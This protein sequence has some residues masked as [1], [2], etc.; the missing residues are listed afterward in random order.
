[1]SRP[2]FPIHPGPCAWSFPDATEADESGIVCAGADLEPATLLAAY[3]K[4]LVPMRLSGRG[5][6]LAWWAPD[7]RGVLPLDGFHVSRSLHKSR[8]K[9]TVTVDMEFEAV[10]GL[11]GDPRRPHGWITQD[12]VTAYVRMHELGW[13]HSFEVWQDDDLVGGMYGLRIK[14]FFAGESMFSHKTDASKIA[15]WAATELLRSDGV[16][17][18][19]VQWSTDHLASLGAIE[20]SCDEYLQR[21][22]GALR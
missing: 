8:R 2:P 4:G 5:G 3:S 9:F 18:F 10:I 13:A 20:V 22:R 15:L 21:L 12:F 7:P 14:R 1:M 11:C 6:Q 19:D 16:E 17:L